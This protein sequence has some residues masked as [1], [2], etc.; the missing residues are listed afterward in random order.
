MKMNHIYRY[1]LTVLIL[2]LV[3]IQS[4]GQDSITV[5][6]MVFSNGNN[7]VSNVSISIE[8]SV[9]LPVVTDSTGEFSMQNV[10]RDSWIII[11]PTGNYKRKRIFLSGRES[12]RIYLTGD[13]IPSGD[14]PLNIMAQPV[15]RRNMIQAHTEP[16]VNDAYHSNIHSVDQY[17]QGQVPG[18]FVINRSGM[19]GSGAV[20]TL[21]GVNSINATNQPLY[22]ID[23]IPLTSHGIFGSNLAGYAHNP[24]LDI[25]PADISRTLVVKDPA[26]TSTYGS[27]ASNG[28]IFIETL[29]PRVTESTI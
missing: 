9:Q 5:K 22:V 1:V 26:L 11:A 4:H 2:V 16:D 23:G 14:D 3:A 19:P 27:R 6:G 18:M 12:L 21:R 29:D 25:N 7:P 28:L 17:M 15:P 24:L 10:A 13:D 8:G 20:T